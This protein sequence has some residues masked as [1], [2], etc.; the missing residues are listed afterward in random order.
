MTMLLLVELLVFICFRADAL[1][2]SRNDIDSLGKFKCTDP[3]NCDT[4]LQNYTCGNGQCNCI[5][6]WAC[7]IRKNLTYIPELPSDITFV[8]FARNYLPSISAETFDNISHL[9]LKKLKLHHN[10]IKNIA[11]D[12]FA[13]LHQIQELDLRGNEKINKT[14]LAKSFSSIQKSKE[15]TLVLDECGLSVIPDAFFDKLKDSLLV[16]FSL[17]KNQMKTFNESQFKYLKHLKTID[18][19][20]NWIENIT[21]SEKEKEAGLNATENLILSDNE[22]VKFPP[23][24]CTNDSRPLYPN[25]KSLALASNFIIYP[26]KRAWSCLK[27]L[28]ILSLRKNVLF[29]I[30]NDVFSDLESLEVLDVSNMVRSIKIIGFRAFNIPQLKVLHFEKN[31]IT[32]KT[33]SEIPFEKLFKHLQNL[34]TIHLES[35]DFRMSNTSIIKMLSPLKNLKHLHLGDV[36][37]EEIPLGLLGRFHN[38]TILNLSK[39]RISKIDPMAFANVTKLEQIFLYENRIKTID[40]TS[41]P[42]AV[43]KSLKLLNLADNPFSCKAST[44]NNMWFRN[45][46]KLHVHQKDVKIMGWPAN[47]TCHYPSSMRGESLQKYHPTPGDCK[48]KDPPKPD[49]LA[50]YISFALFL[51]TALTFGVAVYRGRWYIK[52][53]IYK[54]RR[55]H[56]RSNN[57]NPESQGLLQD[58]IVYDAY[59]IYHDLDRGFVRQTLLPFMEEKH[60]YKLFITDRDPEMGAKVDIIADNIYR[61]NH[62]I[63]LVSRHFLKDQWCEFQLAI[64]LDRQVE[65]KRNYLL[66]LML[67]DVDRTLLSKT[68]C[69][70]LTRTPTADWCDSRNHIKRKLFEYQLTTIIQNKNMQR[71]INM[72]QSMNSHNSINAVGSVS[73][74]SKK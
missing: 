46:I 60:G 69:V 33:N 50:V 67:E 27:K 56:K 37:F 59:V 17:Q 35:N 28:K 55:R 58:Q 1:A 72:Q 9:A 21:R 16:K 23:W 7:C 70:L 15:L 24:F 22:I 11:E 57:K 36:S 62:V 29:T 39:N 52:Y 40:K 49:Y 31:H 41:F 63:A 25:L 12:S 64:T 68:W 42:K 3:C 73:V 4:H 61:S 51:V 66:L 48:E 14:Q 47:Y 13:E 5:G 20:N 10:K 74:E 8:D 43:R 38:L 6:E 19:S 44:C 54:L 30:Q 53:W 18:L 34:Q 45:W 71:S 65:L 2:S 26:V 32:F